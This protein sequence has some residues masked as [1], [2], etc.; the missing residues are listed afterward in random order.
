MY[1]RDSSLSCNLPQYLRQR[2]VLRLKLVSSLLG[3]ATGMSV[4]PALM[5]LSL[6]LSFPIGCSFKKIYQTWIF[7]AVTIPLCNKIEGNSLETKLDFS[8]VCSLSPS[9]ALAT[10]SDSLR[11][12][13]LSIFIFASQCRLRSPKNK[14][15]T[16]A[17]PI[18][19][20]DRTC[21]LAG[22]IM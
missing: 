21:K 18:F 9:L 2:K 16:S 13:Y 19:N 11:Y 12:Q 7:F 17:Q 4:L 20:F 22:K 14:Q 15:V 6:T 3:Q 5:Y 8:L 10:S 1:M